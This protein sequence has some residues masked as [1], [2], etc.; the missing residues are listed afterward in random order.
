MTQN[1]HNLPSIGDL[2]K[3]I[4]PRKSFPNVNRGEIL[5]SNVQD[6][7]RV[8]DILLVTSEEE[9]EYGTVFSVTKNGVKSEVHSVFTEKYVGQK[10]Q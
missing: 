2:C 8:G 4:D 9:T 3:I 7:I 5:Y 6:D 1:K 10:Q